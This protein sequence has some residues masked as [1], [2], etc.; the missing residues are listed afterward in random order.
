L[1]LV[2]LCDYRSVLAL[3]CLIATLHLCFLIP[4]CLLPAISCA[5]TLRGPTSALAR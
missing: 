5:L 1:F 4:F 2:H 3:P